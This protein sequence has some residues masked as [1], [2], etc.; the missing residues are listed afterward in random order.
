MTLFPCLLITLSLIF[1]AFLVQFCRFSLHLTPNP[2]ETTAIRLIEGM[3]HQYYIVSSPSDHTFPHI[4]AFLVYFCRFSLHLTPDP[5]ETTAIRLIEG[6][7]HQYN[8]VSSPSDHTFPHI[9]RI[10]GV[11]L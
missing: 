2:S 4:F 7:Y 11:F 3:Y 10:F 9:F 6:M 1:F 8:I 5:F